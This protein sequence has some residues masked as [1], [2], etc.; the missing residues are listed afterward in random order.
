VELGLD[1]RVAV[2]LDDSGRKVRITVC[3]YNQAKI[4]QA[5][6]QDFGVLEHVSNISCFYGT[7]T[8]GAALV[9]LEAVFDV[10][11]LGLGQPFGFFGEI[12]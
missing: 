7:L 2:A 3:W 6:N 4:H 12:G 9:D 5:T 11:T 8:G 1:R 10:G